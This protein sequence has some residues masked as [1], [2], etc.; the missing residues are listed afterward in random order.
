[1]RPVPIFACALIASTATVAEV[2]PVSQPVN[3]S[4][5]SCSPTNGHIVDSGYG[6]VALLAYWA[7]C[8]TPIELDDGFFFERA[9]RLDVRRARVN[10]AAG[11]VDAAQKT[12][13]RAFTRAERRRAN[14]ANWTARKVYRFAER[15][16]RDVGYDMDCVATDDLLDLQLWALRTN[17]VPQSSHLAGEP[18]IWARR[19][20]F[21]SADY[22]LS[23]DR[24][25]Q[26]PT[27]LR[28]MIPGCP[29]SP[30]RT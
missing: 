5:L 15:L 19:S 8:Q 18:S 30:Y 24:V 29:K 4:V 25:L 26:A 22:G 7:Q 12:V 17:P 6:P 27:S 2:K 21:R 3:G 11:F 23:D 9:I 28:P 20:G 10:A 14:S 1:M 16:A 13:G